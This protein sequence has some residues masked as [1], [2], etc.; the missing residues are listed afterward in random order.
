MKTNHQYSTFL[1]KFITGILLSVIALS[2]QITSLQAKS[3]DVTEG[4]VRETI[5]GTTLSSAYMTLTNT[6]DKALKLVGASSDFSPRIEIHEHSMANGMMSMRQIDSIIIDANASVVL[7]PSGL[8]LM[9]FE[10]PSP[11]KANQ[12]VN[13]TLHF[14]DAPNMDVSLPVKG[15]KRKKHH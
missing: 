6:S 10:L 3:L 5:P 15:I 12:M 2:L 4:F 13:I 11:L 1:S 7:Q 8:H 9:I 14:A